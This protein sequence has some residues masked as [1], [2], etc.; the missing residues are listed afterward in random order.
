MALQ[1]H[2]ESCSAVSSTGRLRRAP[3]DAAERDL[4]VGGAD[5]LGLQLRTGR[6]SAHLHSR[7]PVHLSDRATAEAQPH[8]RLHQL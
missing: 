1:V 2:K 8:H 3:R 6:V 7:Q 5:E 4:D